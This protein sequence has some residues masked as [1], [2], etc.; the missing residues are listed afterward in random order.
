MDPTSSIEQMFEII[1][2]ENKVQSMSTEQIKEILY[3]I[4]HEDLTKIRDNHG[5]PLVKSYPGLFKPCISG[6]DMEKIIR[7]DENL[8][9]ELEKREEK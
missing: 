5:N 9:A 3:I 4:Q 1:D 6:N 7:L 2:D 8:T